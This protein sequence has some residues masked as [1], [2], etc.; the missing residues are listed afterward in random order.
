M[1][2]LA[3]VTNRLL[4]YLLK[5]ASKYIS[6]SVA[7]G[8]LLDANSYPINYTVYRHTR[9]SPMKTTEIRPTWVGV[10]CF[11]ILSW[12]WLTSNI[13]SLTNQM[14]KK[15]RISRDLIKNQLVHCQSKG[16]RGIQFETNVWDQKTKSD[17]SLRAAIHMQI[18]KCVT[19]ISRYCCFGCLK[20]HNCQISHSQWPTQQ[21]DMWWVF[22]F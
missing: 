13:N 22:T 12:R 2:P 6:Q 19:S 18:D 21:L 4:V 5:V 3:F 16:T 10:V 15:H 11:K 17:M 14:P 1:N 9:Y 7:S 8:D 20:V